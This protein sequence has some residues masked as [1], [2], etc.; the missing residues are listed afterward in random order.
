MVPNNILRP[1]NEGEELKI[2]EGVLRRRKVTDFKRRLEY[3]EKRK[4][5]KKDLRKPDVTTLQSILKRTRN[6]IL[7]RRRLKNKD[8]KPYMT[9]KKDN[10]R[11]IV[12]VVRNSRY[13]G[14]SNSYRVLEKLRLLKNFSA[15]ILS[16]DDETMK[17]LREIKP[18]VFYGFPN[19]ALLKTLVHK[20]GAFINNTGDKNKGGND[21]VLLTDN[22]IVE[23]RLGNIGVLCTEDIVTGIWNGRNEDNKEIFDSILNN[24]AP[25]QL[26]NLKKTEG[27]DASKYE[28]GFLGKQINSKISSII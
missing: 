7:D 13:C 18:Y 3:R 19:H 25:F 24:L 4:R 21:E 5:I 23:E 17:I 11:L 28:M 8:K 6:S 16:H 20:K 2:A 10:G 26:C 27:L 1:K 22:N 12:V 14:S 15:I 9:P